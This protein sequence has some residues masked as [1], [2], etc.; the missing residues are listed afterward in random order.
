MILEI[1]IFILLQ[2][3]CKKPCFSYLFLSFSTFIF[4]MIWSFVHNF[5]HLYLK[6]TLIVLIILSFYLVY[7]FFNKKESKKNWYNFSPISR[8]F[9]IFF[10]VKTIYI[11]SNP[12]LSFQ[13]Y[14]GEKNK[15]ISAIKLK[16]IKKEI[17]LSITDSLSHFI[18]LTLINAWFNHLILTVLLF[19]EIVLF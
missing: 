8:E 12:S 2:V 10:R 18:N 13:L 16:S 3:Y 11:N 17:T 19:F 6:I 7:F 1:T 15:V 5:W 9:N 14:N 4:F